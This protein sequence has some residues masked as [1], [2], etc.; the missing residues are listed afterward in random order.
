M[1]GVHY[2]STWLRLHLSTLSKENWNY[3]ETTIART[4]TRHPATCPFQTETESVLDLWLTYDKLFI[5]NLAFIF[6]LNINSCSVIHRSKLCLQYTTSNHT[7]ILPSYNNPLL[8]TVVRS[9]ISNEMMY[10][11]I[12]MTVIKLAQIF[13]W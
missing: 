4:N 9:L 5:C 12:I 7:G 10:Y 11:V 13:V 1:N 2:L 6:I 8:K 3:W